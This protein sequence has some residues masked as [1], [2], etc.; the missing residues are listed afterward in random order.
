MLEKKYRIGLIADYLTSEYIENL[1][2]GIKNFCIEN[3]VELLL[4]QFGDI[5]KKQP[6]YN[7]FEF[8]SM[9]SHIKAKNLDGLLVTSS[10][11]LHTLN[12]EEYEKYLHQ[13]E[14]L[15]V[16][17]I[18]SVQKNVH[19]V[20]SDSEQAYEA[21]INYVVAEQKCKKFALM[22]VESNTPEVVQRTEIFKRVLKNNGLNP[23]DV[24]YFKTTF[25][26]SSAYQQ[27]TLYRREHKVIDFDA[28][29]ALNDETAFACIDFC[30]RRMNLNVPSD[31]IITGFDNVQRASFCNPTLS[32]V[33]QQIEYIGFTAAQSLYNLL[34]GKE[35][36]I[37]QKVKAKAILRNSTARNREIQ[38]S[39]LG[40]NFISVDTRTARDFSSTYTVAEWYNKR[41]Q[42]MQAANFY[43]SLTAN[44][45]F[46]DV[47]PI[48]VSAL[49]QFGFQGAAIVVYDHPVDTPEPFDYF[50]FPKRAQLIAGFDYELVFNTNDVHEPIFFNPNEKL[51]PDG[52]L[53]TPSCGSIVT[54]LFN[55]FVQYGYMVLRYDAYDLGVY[56]LIQHAISNL[57]ASSYSYTK[58]KDEQ[59]QIKSENK[60]LD[61]I[62][63]TD[64]LT[65]LNNRR[66]FM[67]FGQATMENCE[68]MNQTGLIVFCDMDGLKKIND[69]FGHEAGDIA[70]KAMSEILNT[71]FRS[72]DILGRLGGDE[73]ALVCPGLN[74]MN[75]EK[76]RERI[77]KAC[78]EWTKHN[79]YK[80][81][82]SI[83]MGTAVF[84]DYK[85]GYEMEALLSQADETLYEEKHMK[86]EK[87]R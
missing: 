48:L 28:I 13:F 67:D 77:T 73:F 3:K 8:A 39:F 83:S 75:F 26:Y 54:A 65:G 43:N 70:I 49:R 82:L 86:K 19:S 11:F 1:I 24:T 63:H 15:K 87:R 34:E 40:N 42:I 58:L 29:V 84:P 37:I 22:G 79:R 61:F 44:T 78:K 85:H 2:N 57:L 17:N 32:S 4:F 6:S 53:K 74:E 30:T 66:G 23:D 14:P 16:V 59:S 50:T 25:D 38:K 80:F 81:E 5:A 7:N 20:I 56:D 62:A 52:V 27:L 64:E 33:N 45:Y 35:V 47:G 10:T 55:G 41:N 68:R 12:I 69:N 76:I 31:I 9:L 72:N 36:P 71:T 51:L 18:A 60:H 46:H 21:L